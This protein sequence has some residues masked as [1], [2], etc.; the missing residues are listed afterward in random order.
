MA[1]F[2][3]HSQRFG[4][5]SNV[6]VFRQNRGNFDRFK[7]TNV[8][9][10][11]LLPIKQ[12]QWPDDFQ[13]FISVT[14]TKFKWWVEKLKRRVKIWTHSVSRQKNHAICMAQSVCDWLI[15]WWWVDLFYTCSSSLQL[16]CS[17]STCTA[18]QPCCTGAGGG[19]VTGWTIG[20]LEL[21]Q[22]NSSTA[23][24]LDWNSDSQQFG[25]IYQTIS[26]ETTYATA[27]S[28]PA[29]SASSAFSALS[30]DSS[31]PACLPASDLFQEVKYKERKRRKKHNKMWLYSSQVIPCLYKVSQSFLCYN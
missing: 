16:H 30:E 21:Q 5:F 27:K 20:E 17:D 26:R 23:Q 2:R 8:T 11:Y 19:A 15:L 14:M 3:S 10:Q 4:T 1:V 25:D 22:L 9:I 31:R 7:T 12:L 18:A 6:G 28:L 13:F 24:R 29:S